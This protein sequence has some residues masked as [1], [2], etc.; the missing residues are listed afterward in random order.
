[1]GS[2]ISK[3]DARIFTG[4]VLKMEQILKDD[5]CKKSPAVSF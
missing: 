2:L 3:G 5:S 4:A 1:M